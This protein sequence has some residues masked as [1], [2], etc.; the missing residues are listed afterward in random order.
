MKL[1]IRQPIPADDDDGLT[2]AAARLGA[3]ELVLAVVQLEALHTEVSPEGEQLAVVAT[4][5]AGEVLTDA[6]ELTATSLLDAARDRRTGAVR[7]ALSIGERNDP[8][9]GIGRDGRFDDEAADDP[10]LEVG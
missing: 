9:A 8:D 5:V 2:V 4:I 1:K 7:F 6:D 10:P 3:G